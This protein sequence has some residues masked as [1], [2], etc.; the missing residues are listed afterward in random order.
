MTVRDTFH[1]SIVAELKYPPENFVFVIFYSFFLDHVTQE[2]TWNDPRVTTQQPF[3]Q[4]PAKQQQ[5]RLASSILQSQPAA[6]H[7]PQAIQ[8]QSISSSVGFTFNS[9]TVM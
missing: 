2:T 1:T 8:L 5:H 4:Q 7:Q 6:S 9:P 3:Y